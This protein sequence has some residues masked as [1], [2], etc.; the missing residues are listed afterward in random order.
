MLGLGS[1]GEFDKDSSALS[2]LLS[3][4]GSSW[5]RASCFKSYL[6]SGGRFEDMDE[7]R[8]KLR[9]ISSSTL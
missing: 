1:L 6:G 4:K 7:T 5:H 9:F 8:T 2:A 3:L